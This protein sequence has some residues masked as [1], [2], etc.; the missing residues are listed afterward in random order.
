MTMLSAARPGTAPDAV[1]GLVPAHVARPGSAQEVAEVLRTG[2]GAVVPVG[3]GSKVGWAAP[4]TSL[5]T[6]LDLSLSLIHISEPTRP[7]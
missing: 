6:V 3:S 4:P 1:G 7:Y 2:G 5:D